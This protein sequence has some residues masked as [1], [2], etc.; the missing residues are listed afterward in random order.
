MDGSSMST[1]KNRDWVADVGHAVLGPATI[2]DA[3]IGDMVTG[4]TEGMRG[5]V[6]SDEIDVAK[7]ALSWEGRWVVGGTGCDTTGIPLVT[8]KLLRRRR[9]CDLRSWGDGLCF[10]RSRRSRRWRLKMLSLTADAVS[11]ASAA[12]LSK[13]RWR[14]A[15]AKRTRYER[16][17]DNVEDTLPDANELHLLLC[18][19]STQRP[20]HVLLGNGAMLNRWGRPACACVLCVCVVW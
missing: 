10:C 2:G 1:R 15:D 3:A 6:A 19:K 9:C 17:T 13:R 20:T 16:R 5:R 8:P 4:F 12:A 11:A 14:A 7:D 18:R